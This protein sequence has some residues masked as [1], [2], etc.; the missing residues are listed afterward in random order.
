M[1]AL[2]SSLAPTSPPRWRR[3][4][5]CVVVTICD[6]VSKSFWR[7]VLVRA[8]LGAGLG[9]VVVEGEG[10]TQVGAERKAVWIL[11]DMWLR[12]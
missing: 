10:E 5:K 2:A 6:C 1:R 7:K 11:V 9:A 3:V 8:T 12:F 4:A